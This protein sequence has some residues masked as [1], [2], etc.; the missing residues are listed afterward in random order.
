MIALDHI[1]FQYHSK[2]VLT[3]ISIKIPFGKITAICGKNGVGKSTLLKI[4]TGILQ[5]NSGKITISNLPE[6]YASTHQKA[7]FAYVGSD[8]TTQFDFRVRDIVN[9]GRFPYD[10][11]WS[12]IDPLNQKKIDRILEITGLRPFQDRLMNELSTGEQQRVHLAR[13]LVQDAPFLILDEP[14]IHLD[15][16]QI[17][18]WQ[19][20][21]T[22]QI[23]E[24]PLTI[25]LVTH[26]LTLVQALADQVVLLKNGNI[27]FIGD[28]KDAFSDSL[29]ADVFEIDAKLPLFVF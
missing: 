4:I 12:R 18:V 10:N 29:L 7:Y 3:D 17:A 20:I 2:P 8:M 5:P 19:E 24:K 16:G 26:Q 25:I 11:F 27:R 15:I 6:I 9:L 28:T 22:Q 1:H 13:A 14:F 23:Q 21:I